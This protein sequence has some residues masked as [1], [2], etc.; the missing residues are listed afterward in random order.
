MTYRFTEVEATPQADAVTYPRSQHLLVA[1]SKQ[2]S[3]WWFF[4]SLFNRCLQAISHSGDPASRPFS[5][6]AYY[7]YFNKQILLEDLR[8][9]YSH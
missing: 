4:S 9:S 8:Q 5:I 7:L 2:E 1:E 3:P 6:V